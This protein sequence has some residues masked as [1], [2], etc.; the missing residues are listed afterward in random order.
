VAA[1]DLVQNEIPAAK[2]GINTYTSL[3]RSDFTEWTDAIRI[4]VYAVSTYIFCHT[5]DCRTK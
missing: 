5:Q 4:V 2:A 3:A 1:T